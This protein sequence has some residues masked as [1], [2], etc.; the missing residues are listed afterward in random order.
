[1]FN[2]VA[3]Q[4][5]RVLGWQLTGLI[6]LTA[7]AG[8]LYGARV[9]SS[10]AVGG[11]IGLV[12][13]SYLVFVLIKHALRPARPATVL[14]LFGNWFVK[15]GLVLAMLAIALRSDALVP[16]AVL[17]GLFASLLCYWLAMVIGPRRND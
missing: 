4:A 9:G 12:A 10:L 13:T 2:S 15:T 6:L 17:A 8:G 14:S 11:G 3:R 5:L 16:P 7:C 1:M